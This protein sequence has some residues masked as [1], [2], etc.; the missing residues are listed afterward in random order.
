M[1]KQ[2]EQQLVSSYSTGV[3]LTASLCM[4][5]VHQTGLCGDST[6]NFPALRFYRSF[7]SSSG[8][9]P[10]PPSPLQI[11]SR[12]IIDQWA[13]TGSKQYLAASL[14]NQGHEMDCDVD[15]GRRS[16]DGC[17]SS[18]TVKIN[19]SYEG[20]KL[21]WTGHCF[22]TELWLILQESLWTALTSLPPKQPYTN[23]IISC[24]LLL[25]SWN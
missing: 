1:H 6:L 2:T 11:T 12:K 7:M 21:R 15:T 22:P 9:T 20:N 14:S 10:P 19:L 4:S 18:S 8:G 23:I 13:D 5:L 25:N 3:F 17:S 24:L 16:V